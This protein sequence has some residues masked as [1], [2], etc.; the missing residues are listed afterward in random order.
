MIAKL[1][2]ILVIATLVCLNSASVGSSL[3]V[4]PKSIALKKS[5]VLDSKQVDILSAV[6]R[7]A[8]KAII[9]PNIKDG[10]KVVALFTTWYA[11]NAACTCRGSVYSICLIK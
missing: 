8:P 4:T 10:L 11:A 7:N 9:S 2:V 5:S 3:S 1:L 6:S